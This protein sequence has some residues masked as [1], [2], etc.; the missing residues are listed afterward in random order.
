MKPARPPRGPAAPAPRRAPAAG[1]ALPSPAPHGADAPA[2]PAYLARR[3]AHRALVA[4][5]ALVAAP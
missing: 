5:A 3:A 4:F 2:S 1:G